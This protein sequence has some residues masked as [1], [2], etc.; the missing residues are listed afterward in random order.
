MS[1][2]IPEY[3]SWIVGIL[4]LIVVIYS[5]IQYRDAK[6]SS[7]SGDGSGDILLIVMGFLIFSS[8]IFISSIISGFRVKYLCDQNSMLR[9]FIEQILIY[10]APFL[11]IT[12]FFHFV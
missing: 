6:S 2:C 4:S 10:I 1:L 7:G 5:L 9:A 3:I 8:S 11:L 12:L